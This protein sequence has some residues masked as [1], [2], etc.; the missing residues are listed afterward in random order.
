MASSHKRAAELLC[1]ARLRR[2]PIGPLPED[3][4]PADEADAYAI[5]DELHAQLAAAGWG[6]VSGHKIGCTTPVM[7]EYMGIDH[8]CSGG[9]FAPTVKRGSGDLE[10]AAFVRPGVECE[11]AVRLG[12]DLPPERAPFD[13]PAAAAAVGSC[14]AAMEIV[15]DRF[16]DY[17]IL[18]TPTLVADDFFGA[19]CVLGEEHEGLDPFRLADVRG[20]ML[21]NGVEVGSGT[22]ADI[23]GHPLEALVWLANSV[24]ARGGGLR[25]GEFVLLGSIVRTQWVEPGDEVVILVEPLGEARARF[26]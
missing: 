23:L 15:D 17:T 9:V 12:A 7:Q 3:V 4:R 22:G 16:E 14:M 1:A 2:T 10:H 6:A 11:V 18:G 8:P 19:G 20:T 24:A 13:R 25:V 21:V 5:Q 26:V